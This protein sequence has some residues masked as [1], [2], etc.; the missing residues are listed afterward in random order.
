MPFSFSTQTSTGT[1]DT[2]SQIIQVS[3]GITTANWTVSIAATSGPT[4]LWTEGAKTFDFNDANGGGFSDGAD[5]DTRGGQLTINATSSTVTGLS[6]C[7]TTN[8]TKGASTAFVQCT[9]DSI[10]LLS[11]SACSCRVSIPINW[12]YFKP[13]YTCGSIFF[14]PWL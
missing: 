2:A 4:A 6:G 14:H 10:T 9:T 5:L 13:K 12:R 3:N 1:L 7:P 11:A 8:V